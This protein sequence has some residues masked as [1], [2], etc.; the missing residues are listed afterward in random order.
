MQ[1]L[2]T[3][4]DKY[5]SLSLPLRATIWFTV[6]NFALK[7]ISFVC[8]PLYTRLMPVEEYGR[9]TVITS[10]ETIFIIFATFEIYLG[11]FQR[12]ILTFK[13][14]VQAF[15]SS[16]VLVANALTVINFIIVSIFSDSFTAFTGVSL[17][18]YAVMCVNFLVF[19]PYNCW[20]NKKRFDYDYKAAVSV[21]LAMALLS[22]LLPIASLFIWGQ[23]AEVKVVSTLVISSLFCLPFWL[24]DFRPL[25]VFRNPA[26][27]KEHVVFALKFQ[28]PLVFHSLSYYV[29]NQSDRIM[30]E[31]FSD[32]SKVAFYSVAYSL[33]TVIILLQNSLNQVLKP[34]RY[35]TL[36]DK[37]YADVRKLSNTV[38]VLIGAGIIAFMLIVPEVFK[39]LFEV[40]YHEALVCIPPVTTGV[41][42]L[43]LYTIFVDV[44]SYYGKTNYIAYVSVFSAALNILLNYLGLRY[45][46]YVVCAYT[47]LICYV[48]MSFLHFV[49]M[50][51]TCREAEV[52]EQP[53]DGKFIW[54]FS[55]GILVAFVCINAIYPNVVIRYILFVALLVVAYFNR[56]RIKAMLLEVRAK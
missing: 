54:L 30:I 16:V 47:T 39:F 29:L 53:I 34:W 45:F 23:T 19:A 37:R 2:R 20:L 32:A 4:S 22:N 11:A 24:K 55:L 36:E 43:F 49:F 27:V 40:E 17:A 15:E 33:A 46:D 50:K 13:E 12:G 42:F 41:F 10:Y 8:M 3:I 26:Q 51:R 1:F 7:G 31:K 52:P 6:C 25:N 56:A 18:L 5:H 35:K 28:A 48:I 9:M 44:E 21:T 38:V 14:D